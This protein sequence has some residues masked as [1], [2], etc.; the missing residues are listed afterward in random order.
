M[1]RASNGGT[2][3]TRP[4]EVVVV[5]GGFGGLACATALSRV[6]VNLAL[7]DRENYHL[8]Q[9]LL[10]QVAMA[11]LAPSEIAMPIRAVVSKNP[12]A[13][14]LLGEVTDIDEVEHAVVLADGARLSFDYLVVA[15]GSRTN[16]F[17][18][19]RWAKLAAGMKELEDALEIRRRVLLAFE[20][21]ERTS[22]AALRRRLLTFV[23]IGGGPTGVELAG[24]LAELSRHVLARDFRVIQRD[25]ARVI[26]VEG[27]DRVLTAFTPALSAKAA[28]SLGDLGVELR[29]SKRVRAIVPGAVE[30]DGETLHSSCVIWAAGVR[31][32]SLA[33]KAPGERDRQG[34]VVVG[35]DC[36]IPGHSRIFVIGDMA[37][38][39]AA[40]GSPLPGLAPVA[41]QQG[42]Y[43]ARTIERELRGEPRKPFRYRD[44]G[45]MATIGRSRAVL[46]AGSL[47]LSGFFAWF[48]WIFVHIM[49]LVGFRNRL[50]VLMDWA[51]SYVT[52]RRGARLITGPTYDLPLHDPETVRGRTDERTPAPPSS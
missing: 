8:F 38:Q 48:A 4:I 41:M 25:E 5:G 21:A 29:L 17:G 39:R 52:Y 20:L 50:F 30:L 36:A 13:R 3:P 47:E 35:E 34:R 44:K 49:Y 16:Y 2:T 9:P 19:D 43:V 23:V 37:H 14:V 26:L 11:G 28:R 31:P 45:I 1:E 22:D 18:N 32:R 42:R 46:Q 7:V 10:Y 40:D 6:P 12:R 15:A 24:A 33:E 51:Y 27:L